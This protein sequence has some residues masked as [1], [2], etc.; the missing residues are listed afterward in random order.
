MLGRCVTSEQR[1]P[2]DEYEARLGGQFWTKMP[3]WKLSVVAAEVSKQSRSRENVKD[4]LKKDQEFTKAE[5]ELSGYSFEV[6]DC[7]SPKK[8]GLTLSSTD[9]WAKESGK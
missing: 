1:P 7:C 6:V 9:P 3:A 5:K 4:Q 2:P 8:G